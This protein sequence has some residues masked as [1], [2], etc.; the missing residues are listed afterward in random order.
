M[1]SLELVMDGLELVVDG[2][3]LEVDGLAAGG[4]SG[5]WF[6]LFRDGGWRPC[7]VLGPIFVFLSFTSLC[8]KVNEVILNKWL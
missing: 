8:L 5:G 1:D 6:N 2:L 3:E 4:W 7:V